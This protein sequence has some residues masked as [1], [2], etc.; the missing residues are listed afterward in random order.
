[1]ADTAWD[2]IAPFDER[3]YMSLARMVHEQLVQPRDVAMTGM[4]RALGIEKSKEFAPDKP[5]RTALNAATQEAHAWFMN[6]FVTYGER[7]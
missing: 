4:L 2:T 6:R 1:M 5:T 7:Y 3:F